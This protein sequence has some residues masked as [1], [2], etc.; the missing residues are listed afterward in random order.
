MSTAISRTVE[1]YLK[2]ILLQQLRAPGSSTGGRVAMGKLAQAMNVTAGTSTAMV[3]R[4]ARAGLLNYAPYD[5]VRLTAR[6]QKLAAD[7]LRRHRLIETFLVQ[8][9][10][11]DWSEVHDEAEQLE[12]AISDKLLE[13]IDAALG[14]PR[15]DPHGDPIPD[16]TGAI[17]QPKLR[18]LADCTA[19][20][21][22]EI[23]R[24]LDQRA[25]FLDF[26]DKAGLRPGVRITIIAHDEIA[27][28]LQ[29]TPEDGKPINLGSAASAKILVKHC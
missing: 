2:Q 24:I 22:V 3:K 17:T 26:L 11:L 13:R 29:V 18:S 9:L 1:D 25:E 4:L 20:E 6:G 8:T 5:G 14:H 12:H 16:R 15:F 7:M 10:G 19:N 28:A 23:A 21:T 27:D